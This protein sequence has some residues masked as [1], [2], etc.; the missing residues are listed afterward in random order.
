MPGNN[1]SLLIVPCCIPGQFKN[2]CCEVLHDG[3]QVDWSSRAHPLGVIAL[4]V[5][6]RVNVELRRK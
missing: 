3:S 4:P 2:L 6:N 5:D 1:S